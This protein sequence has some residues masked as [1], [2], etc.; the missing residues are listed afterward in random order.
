MKH[1]TL[2][3]GPGDYVEYSN[4]QASALAVA[5]SSKPIPTQA[6]LAAT[7]SSQATAIAT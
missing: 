5:I 1:K 6:G 3:L 4:G 7:R 2:P